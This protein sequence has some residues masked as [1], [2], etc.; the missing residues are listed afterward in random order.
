MYLKP[1]GYAIF[2][3]FDADKVITAVGES[4]KYTIHYTNNKGE[5]KILFEILKK[6]SD[7][8]VKKDVG[9]GNPID[10]HN[11][12]DFQEGVYKT[13]YLVG[14]S[15]LVSE[16]RKKCDLELIDTDTFDNQFNIHRDYFENIVKYEDNPKT[17]EFLKKTAEFYNHEDSINQASFELSSLNRYY[18]FRRN[19]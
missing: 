12:I 8:D 4:D 11:A 6:Y 16:L 1:G 14:K 5:K 17:N 3:C 7:S 13:E 15:F 2:T 9:I 19:E 10:I 18:I